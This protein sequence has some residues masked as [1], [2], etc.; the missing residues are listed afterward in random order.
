MNT[1]TIHRDTEIKHYGVPGTHWGVRRYQNLDGSYKPGAE[2]RYYQAVK[3]AATK[4]SDLIKKTAELARAKASKITSIASASKKESGSG[5]GG[6]KTSEQAMNKTKLGKD[7]DVRPVSEKKD[8]E[9]EKEAKKSSKK[10]SSSADSEGDFKVSQLTDKIENLF[11]MDNMS[12]ADWEEMDL[13]DSDISEIDD[14]IKKYR[15]WRGTNKSNTKKLKKIDEFI[16]RYEAWKSSHSKHSESKEVYFEHHGV[17]GM[18][19]G[20]RK[21]QN[22]DGTYTTLGKLRRKLKGED[23]DP[24]YNRAHGK[25]KIRYL[26][27]D[28]LKARNERLNLENNYLRNRKQQVDL[29]KSDARQEVDKKT[30]TIIDKVIVEPLTN[31]AASEMKKHLPD[32]INAGKEYYNKRKNG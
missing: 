13:S 18:H 15:A 10:S 2:G 25:E 31:Y 7:I 22:E 23:R 8:P 16:E 24:D 14:L 1:Y 12:D 26:S 20:I 32:I 28:E 19:W 3:N 5:G 11:D 6:D 27:S 29:L 9:A 21:Y 30:K 4:R 17:L